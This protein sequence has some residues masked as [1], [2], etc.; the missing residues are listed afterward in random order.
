MR[1]IITNDDVQ[2]KLNTL[3]I[4]EILCMLDTYS[5]TTGADISAAKNKL[6]TDDL[7][8]RL[9]K[10]NINNSCP[11]CG[12]KNIAKNGKKNDIIHFKCKECN[13][14]FTLFTGTILE[15]TKIHWD[16]WI[17]VLEMT[18]NNIPMEHMQEILI[19]DFGLTDLNYK[20][21]FLWKHKLINALAQ[22]PMP[23]LSGIVQI[24]ETFFREG[25]KGSRELISTVE[26]EDRLPRYGRRPSKYGV[27]GN[28]FANVV[29]ATDLKG[30][31]V[32]KVIGLG[33]L[34]IETFTELFDDY[35]DNP[36]YICSDGNKVYREYCRLKNIPLYIKPSNY[37]ATIA[38]A[39]YETPDWTNP[40]KAKTTEEKNQRILTKLYNE[41]LIDYI[42]NREE[43][44][45]R[46]FY[47]LKNANSLSLARVNQFHSELKCCAKRHIEYNT[48]GVSTK[49]LQDY[50][51]FYTFVRNWRITNGHF[52]SSYKDAEQI[53]IDIL[54]GKTTYKTSD[55]ENAELDLPKVSNRY[56]ELLKTKTEE[57]RTLTSNPYFKY[58]E[59]DNVISFE[60]RKFLEDLPKYKLEKLCSKYKISHKW[61]KYCKITAL[62]KEPT[63]G[64]EILLLINEDRH[65]DISEE[66]IAAIESAKF[67]C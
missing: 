61:A 56:M 31:C 55:L 10:Y 59:E 30:Y 3:S 67:A 16:I 27:M 39:G 19:R 25:Q 21:V 64:E 60:K 9:I 44:S 14:Q 49:Y 2:K 65:Y 58:D 63:I 51:G 42:Y 43:L 20:T 17:K 41:R 18:I 62:L 52:P 50:I 5:K 46:E 37:L 23:K 53:F 28:E 15:K 35:L 29:V 11:K 45:Y 13:K 57:M 24:D 48:R 32:S 38:K 40:T 7:Q 47:E 6:I 34:T 33:K 4:N 22:M 1:K 36:S 8:N 66:D 12:S 54:K 26:G